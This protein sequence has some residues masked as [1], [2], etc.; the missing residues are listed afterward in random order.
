MLK[1]GHVYVNDTLLDETYL[2]S[3]LYTNDGY[4]LPEGQ[5][6]TVPEGKYFVMGDNRPHSSD[7]RA[8]GPITKKEISGIAWVVYWPT[9]NAG[10]VKL[11]K[12]NID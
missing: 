7:S 4:F 1:E 9:S 2:A 3:T 5:P 12:Y 10:A 6:Y 11:P 8:W